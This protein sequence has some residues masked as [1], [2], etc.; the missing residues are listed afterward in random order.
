VA[1]TAALAGYVMVKFYGIIFLGQPREEKLAKVHDAGIW[2]RIGM[3]W[4]AV[5]CIALGVLPVFVVLYIDRVNE[6]LVHQSLAPSA[7]KNG[8]LLLT[9]IHAESASYGPLILLLCIVV[10]VLLTVRVVKKFYHGRLRRGPAWD[11]GYPA[12]TARM[13]DSAEGFGQP[14]RHIFT[15]FVEVIRKLPAPGDLHPH[16]HSETRDRL[17]ELCYMPIKRLN[18]AIS[19]QVGKL[20]HGRIHAYLL[21]SFLTLLALLAFVK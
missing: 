6:M 17:W 18:D 11:C 9:P 12:Q 13:Q 21:Y 20:Q 14:I 5:G 7:A 1:L 8:W 15:N 19:A 16:Y 4:M 2:E 3:T 10:G